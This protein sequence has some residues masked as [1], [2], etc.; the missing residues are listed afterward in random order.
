[1]TNLLLRDLVE[2]TGTVGP[3]WME[4][5]EGNCTAFVTGGVPL[6]KVMYYYSLAAMYRRT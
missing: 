2:A 4:G 5:G 3:G 6:L 1:M